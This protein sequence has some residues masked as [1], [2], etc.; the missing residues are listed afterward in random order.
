MTA[1]I[2]TYHKIKAR[3]CVWRTK[4]VVPIC[5]YYLCYK[6]KTCRSSYR[7]Y[8][9]SKERRSWRR[10]KKHTHT[11]KSR[12]QNR[13]I[14]CAEHGR[15]TSV[16][17]IFKLSFSCIEINAH[18]DVHNSYRAIHNF[19]NM[20]FSFSCSFSF[21]NALIHLFIHSLYHSMNGNKK[22]HNFIQFDSC[23]VYK[24]NEC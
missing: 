13:S 11:S 21:W 9:L 2:C 4:R 6:M 3:A 17:N 16:T 10:R 8:F 22:N 12:S 20:V 7:L 14:E 15:D 5:T 23:T 18:T 19:M 1:V 24:S